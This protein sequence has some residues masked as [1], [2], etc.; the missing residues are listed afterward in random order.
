MNAKIISISMVSLVTGFCL[1]IL[2]VQA[3]TP[4][5][6][7]ITVIAP[8]EPTLPEVFKI[9]LQPRIEVEEISI[10]PVNISINPQKL[11]VQHRTEPIQKAA[12]PTEYPD[13]IY[14]NHIRAGFGNYTTPYIEF[15]AGNLHNPN[16]LLNLQVKHLS[17]HGQIKNYGHSAFSDN[18]ARVSAKKFFD[19]FTVGAKARYDR[20]VLH[21]Y[22]FLTADFPDT[23]F[24]TSENDI[25][26]RFNRF[27][28]SITANSNNKDRE[29]FHYDAQLDYGF[30]NDLF[31]TTENHFG[32]RTDLNTSFRLMRTDD[33]QSLGIK[34]NVDNYKTTDSLQ[35]WNNTIVQVHPYFLFKYQEYEIKAGLG[36]AFDSDTSLHFRLFPMAEGRLQLVQNRLAVFVGV[37]GKVQKNSFYSLANENP[38]I[39]SALEYRNT[40]HKLRFYGGLQGSI[41]K[42]LDY[43]ISGSHTIIGDMPLF[44]ND[45]IAPHNR[46]NVIYDDMN[47]V[48]GSLSATYSI[49]QQL[50]ITTGFNISNYSP[51]NE[52]QAWHQPV[53]RTFFEGWYNFSEK[54]AFRGAVNAYGR[55]WA[56]VKNTD[57][58]LFEARELKPWVDLSLGATYRY[59]DKLHF[60]LDARNLSARRHFYWH[61]YPSQRLNVMAG[62]GFSF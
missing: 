53:F 13:V 11:N 1:Y 41:G 57:T 52:E 35:T 3:Q 8:Y 33:K 23:I 26:Q 20:N 59:N 56:K 9:K 7:E 17:S 44:I 10:P 40:T 29:G 51:D 19:R 14:R 42:R 43:A 34:L 30:I 18:L 60:F 54:L 61:N 28:A 49:S 48:H 39:H 50:R 6:E 15:N 37:D 22:G 31:E 5:R 27:G 45:T 47:L 32:F 2:P 21:H 58:G 16:Y 62:A 46:F 12:L 4:H 36:L 38:F 24:N 55:S 25:K